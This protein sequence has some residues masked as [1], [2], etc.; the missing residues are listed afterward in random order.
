MTT[1]QLFVA[2]FKMMVRNRQTLFWAL[3]FPIIFIVVFGLFN[4]DE[5]TP[6]KVGL[7][8]QAQNQSSQ[9]VSEALNE[10]ELLEILNKDELVAAQAELEQGDLDFILVLPKSFSFPTK[11]PQKLE[12]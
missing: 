8:D 4:L 9:Q 12:L 1:F 7:I 10:I 11:E 3:V 6:S 2:N 5:I